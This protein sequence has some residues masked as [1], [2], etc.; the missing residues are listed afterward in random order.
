MATTESQVRHQNGEDQSYREQS[1]EELRR[2]V[3]ETRSEM[4]RTIDELVDRL[5]PAGMLSSA[6]RTFV[7]G[8]SKSKRNAKRAADAAADTGSTVLDK[9]RDN[10]VP[11][12]LMAVGA[13]WLLMSDDDD[14]EET[15]A[16][17]YAGLQNRQYLTD[18]QAES[19]DDDSRGIGDRISGAAS[20]IGEGAKSAG[21]NVASGATSAASSVKDAG[22]TAAAGV[23]SSSRQVARYTRR[24]MRL[25]REGYET[26]MEEYPLAVGGAALGLGLLCG[27]LVP[28]SEREHELLGPT[29]DSLLEQGKEVVEEAVER[30]KDV[31]ASTAEAAQEKLGEEFSPSELK[32]KVER[33]VAAATETA[34]EETKKHVDEVSENKPS[35]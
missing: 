25:S 11:V 33:T 4:D 22:R 15:E 13:A 30:A 31:A 10:P 20:S 17:H 18:A 29:R 7:K 14:A 21:R 2:E 8:G 12:A 9:I 27:L 19:D 34:T 24:G 23:K 16:D 28:E 3:A 1:S 26:A 6:M 5:N 35:V 32:A